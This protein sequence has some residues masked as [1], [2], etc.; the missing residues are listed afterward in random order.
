MTENEDPLFQRQ[1]SQWTSELRKQLMENIEEPFDYQE[2]QDRLRRTVNPNELDIN[3]IARKIGLDDKGTQ[4]LNDFM[5]RLSRPGFGLPVLNTEYFL[6][7]KLAKLQTYPND[8]PIE[9]IV[10]FTTHVLLSLR[11]RVT[12]GKSSLV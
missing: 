9:T 5:N 7:H 10:K 6:I 1:V 2:A 11:N 4:E 3:V 8:D 12:T